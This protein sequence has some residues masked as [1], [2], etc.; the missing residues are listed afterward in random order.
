MIVK[1]CKIIN[2]VAKY[3]RVKS[4][5]DIVPFPCSEYCKKYVGGKYYCRST[6][7]GGKFVS[8]ICLKARFGL[9]IFS[10]VPDLWYV[11]KN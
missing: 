1:R 8:V 10:Y 11:I 9:K 2:K 3:I 7:Y 4:S 5:H 6:Q